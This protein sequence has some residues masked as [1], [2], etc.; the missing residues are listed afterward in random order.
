MAPDQQRRSDIPGPEPDAQRH[1][2]RD[3][4]T[5]YGLV[6]R[7][8]LMVLDSNSRTARIVVLI[9]AVAVVGVAWWWLPR[10][11]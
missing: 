4:E 6:W 9:L 10:V 3:P 1:Q 2:E 8:A 7:L 5:W 11:V